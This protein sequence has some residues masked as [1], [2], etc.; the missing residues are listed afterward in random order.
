MKA[1]RFTLILVIVLLTASCAGMRTSQS[2]Y[3]DA[4]AYVR[5][6][7]YRAAAMVI[8]ESKG[9]SYEEK[10]RVLYYLDLG[11]LYHYA[12]NY[13]ESN[14]ALTEAEYAIEELYTQSIS[15]AIGSGILND[16]A[17][18]YDGEVYEDL[19]I[20]IFKSLNYIALGNTESALV[21]VRRVNN[22]LNLLQDKYNLMYDQYANS[23]ESTQAEVASATNDFHND[24]LARY[25]GCV[26][27]RNMGDWD[28][29]RID[30][31]LMVESFDRQPQLYPFPAVTPPDAKPV[32]GDEVPVNFFVFTGQ[33]PNKVASTYY[34]DS[35]RNRI[36]FTSVDQNSSDYLY[37]LTGLTSMY[38]PGVSPGLHIKF[39]FPRMENR[40]ISISGIRVYADG[41]LISNLGL[42]EDMEHIAQTTFAKELPLTVGKTVTRALVKAILKEAGDSAINE[43]LDKS[44][45]GLLKSLVNFATDAAV[46]ATE[47]A[48]LRISNF[49]PAQA[50]TGEIYLLPGNYNFTVEYYSGGRLVFTDIKET[51]EIN[52]SNSIIESFFI[53]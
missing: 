30:R 31:N 15:K 10:D 36:N 14:T 25:L 45:L 49:F 32:E 6:R 5:Q 33:S 4:E 38:T 53:F 52:K 46:D 42:T 43:Q 20:N 19:Y 47:N 29:A 48:D 23:G 26:L 22:K 7:N 17:L 9:S 44:G 41:I 34:I 2:Q 16:N 37:K 24:A 8:E 3:A 11:M 27:Y 51:T 18:D 50:Y 1:P 35:G 21:E 39:Q 40:S 13:E 28:D 12:G